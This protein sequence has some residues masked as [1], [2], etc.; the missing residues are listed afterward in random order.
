MTG[1]GRAWARWLPIAAVLALPLVLL[2]S[3]FR[4]FRELDEQKQVYLRERVAEIAARLETPTLTADSLSQLYASDPY[5]RE[6]QVISPETE[7]GTR[8]ELRAIWSG[9]ELY[10]TEDIASKQ[11]TVYRAFIPFH[12]PEGL[13]IARIDIDLDAADFL[14][15][16]AR[17]NVAISI[18]RGL[19][20]I[21]VACY[22]FWMNHRW[23]AMERAHL[24]WQHL[25]NLGQVAAGLAHEIRNPLGTIKGFSQLAA[26]RADSKTAELLAPV[27]S[28]TLR[29]E[30]LVSDLLLYGRP[31]APETRTVFWPDVAAELEQQA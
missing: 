7:A 17:H 8:P 28:E 20:L 2:Y 4:T 30:R 11:G 9:R 21:L 29:L 24:E 26:E 25:A 15:L 10:R 14:L 31:P 6:V 5:V 23:A 19:V 13:R 3:S 22:A 1:T 18:V 27:I 16:H 12:R